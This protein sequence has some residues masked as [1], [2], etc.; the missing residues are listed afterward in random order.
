MC[1][2]SPFTSSIHRFICEVKS[3]VQRNTYDLREK[4]NFIIVGYNYTFLYIFIIIYVIIY[5]TKHNE[6]L[7][8]KALIAL[9]KKKQ[10]K[11]EILLKIIL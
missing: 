10:N 3:Y 6:N 2:V 8:L 5:G 1:P 7:F 9:K 4:H 11:T